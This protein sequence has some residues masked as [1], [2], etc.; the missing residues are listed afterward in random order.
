MLVDGGLRMLGVVVV[1]GG[2]W[3]IGRDGHRSVLLVEM[4]LEE[5]RKEKKLNFAF[6][7][8]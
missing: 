7:F 5:K 4:V 1:M 3:L 8:S 6:G 2:G